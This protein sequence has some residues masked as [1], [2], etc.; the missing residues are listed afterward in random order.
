[1]GALHETQN[2][3]IP[4][5]CANS[6]IFP[7]LPPSGIEYNPRVV[8]QDKLST[9]TS[10][11]DYDTLFEARHGRRGI[12][13]V[14]IS[15]ERVPATSPVAIPNL[16]P[17]MGATKSIMTGARQNHTPDSAYSLPSQRD[18]ASVRKENR[19]STEH[20]VISPV[21]TGHILGEGAAIFTDMTETMLTVLDQQMSLSDMA[22]KPEG[23]SLS[24]ILTPGQISSHG[25]SRLKEAKT[26]PV[27]ITRE[28]DKYPD[29]Y[30]P[31][32]KNYK[33]SD[34]FC[35]YEDS[36]SA[37]NNPVI[38]VELTGLSYRYGTTLYAVDWVNGTMYGKFSG[39]FRVINEKA[40]TDAQYR[41]ASLAGM[42]GP[43]QPMHMSTL[44]GMTQ[45]VAPLAEST[46]MT[47]SLQMPAIPD[48]IP[49]VRDILEPTSNEQ[50][51]S[52]YLENQMRQMGSIS[53]LPS[54]MPSL[55]DELV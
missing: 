30:L 24:K 3:Q 36:M 33:I 15:G 25:D 16:T 32:A 29:L 43:A 35:R 51:R 17:S 19:S 45:M 18:P 46:P 5:R 10:L 7:Y 41:S 22:Q 28:E 26:I 50:A 1:M 44:Q 11:D 54:N 37:D 12:D 21:G 31:V 55:E 49:P 38:L 13:S 6:D 4:P 8:D 34:K 27:P 47:Q 14:P 20:R 53:R 48:R 52:N 42:Y 40:T 9:Y 39:G 2:V 23:P